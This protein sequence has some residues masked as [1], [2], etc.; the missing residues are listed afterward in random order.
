[1]YRSFL[2]KSLRT[3]P[4]LRPP[5][6]EVVLQK[7]RLELGHHASK[8]ELQAAADQYYAE[9]H[10]RNNKV[11]R[12]NPLA[13][14]GRL[15]AKEMAARRGEQTVPALTGNP[16]VLTVMLNFAGVETYTTDDAVAFNSVCLTDTTV[17]TPGFQVVIDGPK[18]NEIPQPTDNNLPWLDPATSATG[19]FTAEYFDLL[20]YSTT[21]YTALMRPEL[22][23]PWDGGNGFD[24]SGVS[25]KNYYLENSRGV[26]DPQGE[27]VEVT[28]PQAVSYF[29]AARCNGA[30]QDDGF[31][32]RPS[33]T[34]AISA[35]Q[36]INAQYPGADANTNNNFRWA[37]WDKEDVFDY[38]NDGNFSEPDGYVDHFFLIEAGQTEGGLYGEFQIWPHSSDVNPSAPGV[39]PAG[40]QLG[41]HQ[42]A[43]DAAHPLGSIWVLNY[44]ISDEVGGLGTLVHEYGHDIGLPDN[45]GVDGSGP[46]P[47]FWDVMDSGMFGGGLSG[48]LPSHMTIW[49]KEFLGWNTPVEIDLAGTTARGA[50]NAA[51]FTIGQQSK[52]PGGAIDGLRIRLPD[53]TTFASVT[54]FDA[55]MWWSDQGDDRNESIARNFTLQPGETATV[56]AQ[57][58]YFIEVD[59]DYF[60]WEISS[61]VTGG[62]TPLEVFSGT[63]QLTTDDNPNGTNPSGNGIN[64]FSPGSDWVQASAVITP[65]AHTAGPLAFRFRYFTDAGF[66]E[67]G[68]YLDNISITGSASGLIFADDAEGGDVWTHASEGI[69]TTKPWLIF[70]GSRSRSQYYLVEWRNSG[71]GTG[72]KGTSDTAAAFDI[73]GFDIGL[74][75]MYWVSQVDDAGNVTKVD[76]FFMHTPGMLIWYV[77]NTYSENTL[78]SFLFD[79]P[80]DGAKGR[81][82]LVDANPYPFSVDDSDLGPR[83]V[84]ERRS[85]FDAAYTLLD[86]P[87]FEL[88]SLVF[89]TGTLATTAIPGE[90]ARPTF[91]DRIGV[92][93]GITGEPPDNAS[94]IDANAG[95][96]LPTVNN[97]PYWAAWDV[98]G[99]TGN[100][101]LEAFGINLEVLEQADDGSWGKVRFWLDDD[102]VFFDKRASSETATPGQ[103]ITYTLNIKDAS[104]T[105]Y[106]DEFN[107]TY[108]ATMTDQLPAGAVYVPGSLSLIE[109]PWTTNP[110]TTTVTGD[111]IMWTGTM[112]GNPLHVPDAVIQYAVTVNATSGAL[113]TSAALEVE[114]MLINT[115]TFNDP[116]EAPYLW[117]KQ[118]LYFAG[119]QVGIEGQIYLPLIYK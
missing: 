55:Q 108:A 5:P 29:G 15:K 8:A 34:I 9:F 10:R 62:W 27:V 3:E 13:Y 113:A 107:Y 54:P 89:S 78:G 73:A 116:I 98:F 40:N 88:S 66:Q 110:G 24:F 93:P 94:F 39:G 11:S 50:A 97:V 80:S 25:F 92:A 70:G 47:G 48:M 41:G 105:R 45:Y 102:T 38:D 74:N 49:D 72:A 46:N 91:H 37:D 65:G 101:G 95:V 64:G 44:T 52:P 22:P 100:P 14:L 32:N 18:F 42:V 69:N 68:V 1:M 86:R 104:G 115:D 75:R 81:V 99:D 7:L 35:A 79:L 118:G 63:T 43:A 58:A 36:Q 61:T 30:Y 23:N 83:L 57:L 76:P 106:A 53:L 82:L 12:P 17:F 28:V 60:Y 85:A 6:E 103:L 19:G 71:E 90:R 84:T 56:T 67:E 4:L 16:Q 96:V 87:A 119:S 77:N 2:L 111:T 114:Q 117:P 51:D 112:G 20:M 21:G 26:Y 109:G 31:N 59:Y 33:Y